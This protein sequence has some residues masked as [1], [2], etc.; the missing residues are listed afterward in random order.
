MTERIVSDRN[1]VLQFVGNK[2]DDADAW[3]Q[4]LKDNGMEASGT[5]V[6]T[7]SVASTATAVPV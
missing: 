4:T 7:E 1:I 2:L 6:K 5:L 3:L